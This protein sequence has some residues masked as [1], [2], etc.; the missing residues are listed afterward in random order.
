M[1]SIVKTFAIALC[2]VLSFFANATD[3]N[4]ATN[5]QKSFAVGM[6]QTINTLQMNILIEKLEGK[7]LSISLKNEK[8]EVLANEYVGKK[9]TTYR[10][11]FDLSELEDGKYSFEITDGA[12]KIVKTVNVGTV[13]PVPASADRF[14]SMN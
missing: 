1:K 10:G 3:K 12:T 11:K 6:Y 14:I 9:G 8:G 7:N 13:S 2:S 5:T 4:E